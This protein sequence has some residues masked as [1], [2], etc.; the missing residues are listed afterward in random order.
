MNAALIWP[1]GFGRMGIPLGLAYLKANTDP[2]RHSV[3]IFDCALRGLDASSPE[4]TR[5]LSAF[6]PGVVGVSCWHTTFD[7]TLALCRRVKDLNPSIRTLV[8][9]PYATVLAA[10]L[11]GRAEVDFVLRGEAERAFPAFL[12]ECQRRHPSWENVK[13]LVYR[14]SG[15][16]LAFNEMDRVAPL[17]SIRPPDYEAI[18]L[19]AYLRGNTRY[20][21]P[22]ANSA[23]LWTTRGCPF[24]C[25]FCA[26]PTLNGSAIR[27]HSIP[28][29][30][31]WIRQLHGRV[32]IRW[33]QILD[34]NF[35]FDTEFAMAFCRGVIHLGLGQIRFSLPNGMR[36]DRG[37]PKLWSLMKAAG[38]DSVTIA[39]ESGSQRVVDR[40]G[41]GINLEA[42][43]PV[44]RDMRRA[45]LRVQAFFMLGFP[46]ET[47]ADLR[48]TT[49]LIRKGRFDFIHF[50]CFQPFRGTP[51]HSALV[52]QGA[53]AEDL[54]PA[55]FTGGRPS[56]ITPGLRGFNFRFYILRAY[57]AWA[58]R[59]PGK[60]AY[61]VSLYGPGH[62]LRATLRMGIRIFGSPKGPKGPQQKGR[63]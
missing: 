5:E 46:G 41:K 20:N 36:F 3:R 19:P 2:N 55:T 43:P 14:Q 30:M 61:A 42:L 40:M 60:I 54:A 25:A 9:G 31:E 8:G 39:P 45:G 21:S 59:N 17:D 16:T 15:G 52:R 10:P 29:L 62:I 44:L 32:A 48:E 26:V 47:R 4:L 57:L 23:P 7:E 58:L 11:M 12:D 18:Q 6:A 22:A 1:K 34:D 24:Q 49:K 33:F 13:G 27:K 63:S 51:V 38:F 50:N 37:G 28:Y 56:Y 35:T 53:I